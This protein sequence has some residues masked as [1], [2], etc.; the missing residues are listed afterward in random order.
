MT[1]SAKL[2]SASGMPPVVGSAVPPPPAPPAGGAN[3][4]FGAVSQELS[5]QA[6]V[7]DLHTL[8]AAERAAL[9][10]AVDAPAV[11]RRD[12]LDDLASRLDA[13]AVDPVTGGRQ[14][15]L[16]ELAALLRDESVPL[17][18]RWERALALLAEFS[19]AEAEEVAP[20]S[21]GRRGGAF[22]KR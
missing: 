9:L 6:R 2:S 8:L 22:W 11:Q 1:R 5:G 12:L 19:T 20:R 16:R 14:A 3:P 13:L 21:R 15:R 4:G 17:A 10:A 7:N 18:Q